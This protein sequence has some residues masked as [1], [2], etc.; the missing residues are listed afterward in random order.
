LTTEE[1][2]YRITVRRNGSYRLLGKYMAMD[3]FRWDLWGDL[4]RIHDVYL[5]MPS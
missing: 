4:R 5:I 3:R 2:K 1:I